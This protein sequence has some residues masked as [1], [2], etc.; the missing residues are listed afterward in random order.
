[1]TRF[2]VLTIECTKVDYKIKATS[3]GDET[4]D[5]SY[6]FFKTLEGKKVCLKETRRSPD[7]PWKKAVRWA[8][9][10][11]SPSREASSTN[12][13]SKAP[14]D[15]QNPPS[16]GSW[17]AKPACVDKVYHVDSTTADLGN[18]F[19]ELVSTIIDLRKNSQQYFP[20]PP[21]ARGETSPGWYDVVNPFEHPHP[22][23]VNLAT[24]TITTESPALHQEFVA[25]RLP[26]FTLEP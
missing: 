13:R 1:V 9:D 6:Y 2:S 12:A 25:A 21:P 11:S 20:V 19:P 5:A 26:L 22:H 7:S 18:E 8:E 4:Q 10:V 14:T 23:V 3:D 24:D 15:N 17:N 16:Y